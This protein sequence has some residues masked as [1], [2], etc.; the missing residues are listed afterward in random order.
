MKIRVLILLLLPVLCTAQTAE[1]IDSIKAIKKTDTI[2]GVVVYTGY[3]DL[4]H[5]AKGDF[6]TYTV[7]ATGIKADGNIISIHT[8]LGYIDLKKNYE[9]IPINKLQ[10]A[11]LKSKP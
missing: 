1:K 9:F 5:L 4:D 6:H 10:S 3:A 2:Q 11:R 7:R 8:D